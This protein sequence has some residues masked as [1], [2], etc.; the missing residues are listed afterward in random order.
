MS[1]KKYDKKEPKLYR[2]EYG[3]W[4]VRFYDEVS[5]SYRNKM[6]RTKTDAENLRRALLSGE[7]LADWFEDA[8]EPAD[9]VR[10]FKDLADRWMDHGKHI[11]QLSTA[12]LTNYECHL[13]NHILPVIGKIS[14]W[15]LKLDHIELVAKELMLKK[16]RTRSYVA[17]RKSR[18]DEDQDDNCLSIAYQREILTV[19]CM[20]T[21]WGSGRKPP[22]IYENPFEAFKLPK[23]PE[24]LYDYWNLE[25]ED[26]FFDW[27][28]AGGFYEKET[29]RY[30]HRGKKKCVIKL[31]IR[32]PD[33]LKDIVQIALRTGMRLGEIGALR[34][35]DVDLV[36]GFIV[37]RGS[38]SQKERKRKNTTKNKKARR[39]EIN[40]D[41]KEILLKRKHKPQMEALFNIHMNSIKFFSRTCR[42]AGV[43]EIHFHSLRHTCLTN[44]ANGYGLSKPLPIPKVQQ[45][46]GHSDI[47]T[48][49]RYVHGD[50]INETASLQW[51]REE[52]LR[53]RNSEQE[54]ESDCFDE[55]T[56]GG[57]PDPRTARGDDS[58]R[59]LDFAR[60]D[61]GSRDDNVIGIKKGLRLIRR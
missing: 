22:L 49:M 35:A 7:K 13:R 9:K 16:P 55:D 56:R 36:R 61:T 30:H 15:K 24:H 60:D 58:R 38:Y 11:R 23:A 52:R 33:E 10:S 47:K 18:W 46:A 34:N 43:K 19:A 20:I 12:C 51:S 42:L 26:Q 17:V 4:R 50:N 5:D 57:S 8:E 53:Q 2:T 40:Q 6:C 44:L 21:S 59:S 29:T 54:K 41:V 32:Q 27:L 14:V 28:D 45:I 39:I 3:S 37:V 48:T 25:D 31:Q 1:R